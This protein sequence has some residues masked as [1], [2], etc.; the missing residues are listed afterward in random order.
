MYTDN[1]Y[2]LQTNVHRHTKSFIIT[3][4]INIT[5]LFFVESRI[6]KRFNFNLN[7]NTYVPNTHYNNLIILIFLIRWPILFVNVSI[8]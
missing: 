7:Y 1:I 4:R 2:K 6:K 8:Y 5:C 3:M